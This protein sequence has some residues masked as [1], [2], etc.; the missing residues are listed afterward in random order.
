MA[1]A[2]TVACSSHTPTRAHARRQVAATLLALFHQLP[3]PLMPPA[4]SAVLSRCVPSAAASAQLLSS[5]LAP[6]EWA[7]ARHVMALLRAAL[8][9]GAVERNGLTVLVGALLAG[10]ESSSGPT[11]CLRHTPQHPLARGIPV[12]GLLL[13]PL[14]PAPAE[15]SW[16]TRAHAPR[17]VLPHAAPRPW[18]RC[19][20]ST[21]SL[22]AAARPVSA[23]A[24]P[25][26]VLGAGATLPPPSSA[27]TGPQQRL[28]ATSLLATNASAPGRECPI[29]PLDS[30]PCPPCQSPASSPPTAW[31]SS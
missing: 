17:A 14:A 27:A 16:V 12:T 15:R 8:A 9:P 30:T 25:S 3:Q 19:S 24:E 26:G 31:P 21:G 29:L 6:A 7:V 10:G 20:Q 22:A 28:K 4:V 18:R 13:A 23:P 5:A 11:G 1:A 2:R